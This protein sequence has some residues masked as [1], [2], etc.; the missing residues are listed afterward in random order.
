MVPHQSALA[1]LATLSE[2]HAKNNDRQRPSYLGMDCRIK[3]GN[4]VERGNMGRTPSAN[5]CCHL[6]QPPHPAPRGKGFA[7]PSRRF[8]HAKS[9]RQGRNIPKGDTI[10]SLRDAIR[11]VQP[12]REEVC[13]PFPKVSTHISKK[14]RPETFRK[15]IQSPSGAPLH[16][17]VRWLWHGRLKFPFQTPSPH[18]SGILSCFFQGFSSFLLPSMRRARV[19]RWRVLRGWMTSSI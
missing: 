9:R 12:S 19:R 15:G 10:P 16:S 3:S 1:Q 13:N 6:H 11:P 17:H 4:D 7:T 8:L 18:Q 5:A 14:P 2:S